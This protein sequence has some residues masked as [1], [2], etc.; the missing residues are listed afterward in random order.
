MAN[1]NAEKNKNEQKK[2]GFNYKT[3]K[4]EP[5]NNNSREKVEPVN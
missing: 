2:S 3:D 1:I 5:I 4:T